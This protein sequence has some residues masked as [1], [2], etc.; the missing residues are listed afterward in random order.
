MRNA[1]CSV[2]LNSKHLPVPRFKNLHVA[3]FAVTL[4]LRSV[5]AATPGNTAPT[6]SA[7]A[8]VSIV[9]SGTTDPI[10]FTVGD[11]ETPVANL[12]VSAVTS[13]TSLVPVANIFL[14]TNSGNAAMR[15]VCVTP[16]PNLTGSAMITLTV[17]DGGGLTA[18]RSFT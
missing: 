3:T 8:D 1:F 11:V 16:Q 5:L 9:Q 12:I 4:A 14:N 7:S 6:M 10:S 18:N 17:T 15:H 13:N 2:V